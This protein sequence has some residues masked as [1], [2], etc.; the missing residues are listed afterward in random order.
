VNVM[1][2]RAWGTR[3]GGPGSTWRSKEPEEGSGRGQGLTAEPPICDSAWRNASK[4]RHAV[5][6][7]RFVGERI[8]GQR[9]GGSSSR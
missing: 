2:V 7:S 3:R 1:S 5:C 4:S 6:G 8:A 9:Q